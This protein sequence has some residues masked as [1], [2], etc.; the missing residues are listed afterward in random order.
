MSSSILLS[1][2]FPCGLWHKNHVWNPPVRNVKQSNTNNRYTF[3]NLNLTRK[4][5]PL[6]KLFPKILSYM[7]Y[8]YDFFSYPDAISNIIFLIISFK[9]VFKHFFKRK[10]MSLLEM[11]KPVSH[12]TKWK[13]TIKIHTQWFNKMKKICLWTTFHFLTCHPWRKLCINLESSQRSNMSHSNPL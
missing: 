5:I 10:L 11:G 1:S 2:S 8:L 3:L 9:L 7:Y 4:K 12:G 13:V 6:W